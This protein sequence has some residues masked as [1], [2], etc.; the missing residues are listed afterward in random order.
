ML[1][2]RKG[3]SNP[4]A[5]ARGGVIR[6]SLFH[7]SDLDLCPG[8]TVSPREWMRLSIGGLRKL[9]VE[10]ARGYWTPMTAARITAFDHGACPQRGC[11]DGQDRSSTQ[12]F[13][14][15][16][17]KATLER[18]LALISMSLGSNSTHP[19]RR[20][21]TTTISPGVGVWS[22]SSGHDATASAHLG[23]VGIR[24][25]RTRSRQQRRESGR[26]SLEE[27]SSRNRGPRCPSVHCRRR[28]QASV[29]R[30]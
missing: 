27:P 21:A 14:N 13:Q 6:G 7:G 15:T 3:T 29:A 30:H 17:E 10:F 24:R 1:Q 26:G 25:R 19:L 11:D 8:P 4:R 9:S 23:S 18:H 20:A 22:R 28:C 5:R 12:K 2:G 16:Y